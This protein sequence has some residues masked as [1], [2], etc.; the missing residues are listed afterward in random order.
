MTGWWLS[1]DNPLSKMWSQLDGD[2]DRSFAGRINPDVLTNGVSG[3][4]AFPEPIATL[5]N[6]SVLQRLM[7][8]VFEGSPYLK[9][10]CTRAPD[11]LARLLRDG[12]EGAFVYAERELSEALVSDCDMAGAMCALRTFK[13]DVALL[14]GLADVGGLWSVD[15]VTATLAQAADVAVSLA[16]EFLFQQ[17]VAR[18]QWTGD[19]HGALASGS[20][21]FV[22]GMGKYGARELNYSSDIDLIVFF[23]PEKAQLKDGLAPQ[24]FYV[25]LVRDLV[26]LIQEQSQ[27]GYVFRVD[28][29]LRPD[30]GST[31]VAMSTDAALIYYENYGQNWERAAF[32]KARPVAGDFS[33]AEALLGEFEAYVWRKYLD[34]AAVADVHAMKRQIHAFKGFGDIAVRGHDVKLGRGGIREIEFFVQTQQLIAGGRQPELRDPRTLVALERL[35]ERQWITPEVR[36]DLSESYRFLRTIEHRLQMVADGQ[37]HVIPSDDVAFSSL[38]KFSGYDNVARFESAVRFHLERVQK[39]Y[40]ALFEDVPELAGA[41]GNLVFAGEADDPGT[42]ETLGGLGFA[43]PETVLHTMRG[44]HHGRYRATSSERARESL[45]DFQPLL[46]DALSRTGNPDQAFVAFD[47]FLADLPAGVQLFSLLRNN[48]NLLRLVADVMG[49]APRLARILSRRSRRLEAILDPGF[50]GALPEGDELQSAVDDAFRDAVDFADILDRARVVEAEHAFLIGVRLLSGTITAEQAGVGYTRLADVLIERMLCAVQDEFSARHGVVPGGAVAVLGMGK[51]GGGEMTASSDVDLILI[52]DF[53]G[54]AAT[55][56]GNRPLMAGQYFS[57]MTQRLVT[58]ISTPTSEGRL[59]EVDMRLRPSGNSGPVATRLSSF[60]DYQERDAWTWE[61]MA[62]LRARCVTGDA[63][64]QTRVEQVRRD[65]L[66]R[67]RDV[68]KIAN[69][70]RE[71]RAL[72]EKERGTDNP[73]DLKLARGGLVDVEFIVQYLQLVGAHDHPSC[74]ERN[75]LQA[76]DALVSVEILDAD[77]GAT[78]RTA[79]SWQISLTQVLRLCVDGTFVHDEAPDGLKSLL[80][81]AVGEPEF[82]RVDEHLRALQAEVR[83]LFEKLIP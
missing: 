59:Y 63:D 26:R 56:D 82:G 7:L 81:Q 8:Q 17:A 6:E 70:V 76:I 21:F 4:I 79:A 48:P 10:L 50:F 69:D 11:R 43:T 68:S 23:D 74:L 62:L 52:Y 55:S 37:T 46:I 25:R 65:T 38:V 75:T 34:Y 30:P 1:A 36:E 40:A 64:L 49:T 83:T 31:Q 3:D 20:G 14:T 42:V 77:D 51:L 41:T 16:L 72:M 33:S 19:A 67:P 54:E 66:I 60:T 28:L 58:A 32:I 15:V 24:Q 44:W 45:T 5:L 61:H 13:A 57:R 80:A 53:E 22:L 18:G 71:M 47:R 9:G 27:D 12:P 29:R 73:W 2:G 78:L 35:A 39:H